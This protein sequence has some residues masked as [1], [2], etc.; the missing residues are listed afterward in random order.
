MAAKS[1]VPNKDCNEDI[2]HVSGPKN[3]LFFQRAC[4]LMVAKSVV[5][6]RDRNEDLAQ[7]YKSG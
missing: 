5:P 2:V 4:K 6:N 1:V 3:G 7:V